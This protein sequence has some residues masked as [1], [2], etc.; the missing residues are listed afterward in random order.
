MSTSRL[1]I[2]PLL[3]VFL[4]LYTCAFAMQ[5]EYRVGPGDILKVT[6]YDHPDLESTLRIDSDGRVLFPLVGQLDIGGT[7]TTEAADVIAKALSDDYVINP[8]VSV[9][10]EDFHSKKVVII[11]EVAKPGMYELSGPTTLLEL[12]SQ[13]G[14]TRKDA[15]TAIS[16][17]R[18]AS[19]GA[20]GGELI[21][22]NLREI[23][24][25]GQEAVD[26]PLIDGDTVT[27]PVAGMVYVTGEVKRPSAYRLEQGTTVIKAITM[28]GGFTE[29]ASRGKVTILRKV[30][31]REEEYSRVPMNKALLPE[32]VI[33]VPESFF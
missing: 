25:M 3:A 20:P 23:L 21:K 11:G 26:I 2:L 1:I 28:A 15:G 10:I 6:V 24:D 9:F 17:R 22:V 29:L 32:D 19:P 4:T 31:G 16:I 33:V 18:G 8:Q 14:G 7:T 13:A 30:D 12:I 5:S 27:V